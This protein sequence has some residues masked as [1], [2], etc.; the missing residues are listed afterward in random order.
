MFSL[1]STSFLVF[2]RLFSLQENHVLWFSSP[3]GEEEPKSGENLFDSLLRASF[4]HAFFASL[5]PQSEGG[6]RRRGKEDSPFGS[7]PLWGKKS[8]EEQEEGRR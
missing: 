4:S 5:R 8:E 2:F 3:T 6:R 7:H 1:F